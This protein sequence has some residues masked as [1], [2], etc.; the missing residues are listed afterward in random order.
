LGLGGGQDYYGIQ[1]DIAT[2]GK[3]IGGGLPCG[4]ITGKNWIMEAIAYTGDS[5]TDAESKPFYGGTF[6][7]NLL[8]MCAGTAALQYL[9]DHP[10]IY[11][12]LDRLGNQLRDGVNRFCREQ[13]LPVQM[14]GVGSMFCTHFTNKNIKSVRDLA[15]ANTEAARAFYPRLLE[16]GV[17]I[18]SIHM[19]FISAAHT[20][21]DIGRVVF[22]HCNALKA[23]REIGLI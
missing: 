14:I 20:E 19:G 16:E 7:G 18:P 1:A 23:V 5:A 9:V 12:E 8:T 4:A 6:N 21:E 10:E 22:A 11:A 15:E 17:F 2:Y 13:E 3:I